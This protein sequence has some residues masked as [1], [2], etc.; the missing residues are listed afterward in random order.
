MKKKVR[1]HVSNAIERQSQNKDQKKTINNAFGDLDKE[2]FQRATGEEVI[3]QWTEEW[4][5][6]DEVG[7]QQ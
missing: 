4:K 1:N 7:K 2:Q 5:I 6:G 3:F